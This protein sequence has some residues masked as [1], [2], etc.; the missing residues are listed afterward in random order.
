MA[1][2][3]RQSCFTFSR[4]TPRVTISEVVLSGVLAIDAVDMSAPPSEI[5]CP[6]TS[7]VFV[8]PVIASDGHTYECSA[9]THHVTRGLKSPFDGSVLEGRFFPPS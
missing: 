3:C 6:L 7:Q 8:D 9:I 5:V 2:Q 4:I 1:P